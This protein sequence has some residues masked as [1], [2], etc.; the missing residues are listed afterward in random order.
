MQKRSFYELVLLAQYHNYVGSLLPL[1][2]SPMR[3]PATGGAKG[4][5]GKHITPHTFIT[6]NNKKSPKIVTLRAGRA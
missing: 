3:P 1:N 2:R 6:H 4:R 5:N